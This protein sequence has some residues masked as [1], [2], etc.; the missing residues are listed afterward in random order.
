MGYDIIEE[1]LLSAVEDELLFRV[2]NRRFM[3]CDGC[4]KKFGVKRDA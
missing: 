1:A 3:V 4:R 2:H